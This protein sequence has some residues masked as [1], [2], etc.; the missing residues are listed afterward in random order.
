MSVIKQI[1][2]FFLIISFSNSVFSQNAKNNGSIPF[3]VDLKDPLIAYYSVT[4]DTTYMSFG[5]YRKGFETKK[6]RE[7]SIKLY[8]YRGKKK[9][10]TFEDLKRANPKDMPKSDMLP[11]FSLN[12]WSIKKPE[13]LKSVNGINFIT[14]EEFRAN[15]LNYLSKKYI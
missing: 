10:K 7:D 4:K 1:T 5:I 14:E 3:L 6:E 13:Y 11:T 2:V 8:S 9:I 12:Y 15:E